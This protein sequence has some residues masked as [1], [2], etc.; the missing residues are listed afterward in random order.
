MNHHDS[1]IVEAD[2]IVGVQMKEPMSFKRSQKTDIETLTKDYDQFLS[3]LTSVKIRKTV[4]QIKIGN[5]Q[6][7]L[8]QLE[9]SMNFSSAQQVIRQSAEVRPSDPLD[10]KFRQLNLRAEE[11]KINLFYLKDLLIK[12]TSSYE[13][14]IEPKN[15]PL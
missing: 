13:E 3:T 10:S 14:K 7:L 15:S 11:K 5:A 6:P 2:L 1:Q 9:N 8:Y 4:N 12:E